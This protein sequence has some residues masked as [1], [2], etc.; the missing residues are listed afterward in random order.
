MREILIALF[1]EGNKHNTHIVIGGPADQSFTVT[2]G[3]ASYKQPW[4]VLVNGTEQKTPEEAADLFIAAF[5][6]NA[7]E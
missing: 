7:P 3:Q 6:L 2:F 1:N 4:A 5:N